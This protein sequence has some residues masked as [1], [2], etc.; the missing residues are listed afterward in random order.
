MEQTRTA[1]PPLR[2]RRTVTGEVRR[3]WLALGLLAVLLAG[4]VPSLLLSPGV[5]RLFRVGPARLSVSDAEVGAGGRYGPVSV[6]RG[7]FYQIDLQADGTPPFT[8][9]LDY[10]GGG[11][12]KRF[13]PPVTFDEA[14]REMRPIIR[15]ARD[16]PAAAV[17]VEITPGAESPPLRVRRLEVYEIRAA[18]YVLR[19]VARAGALFVLLAGLSVFGRRLYLRWSG[20]AGA[21]VPPRAAGW[22]AALLTLA[23]GFGAFV[24][25]DRHTRLFREPPSPSIYGWDGS[26]YY[27]WLRSAMV[28]GDVD[29]A[30]DLRACNSMPAALRETTL[31][32]SPRTPRGL[33][34]NKYPVGWALLEAPW[35]GAADVA[36]RAVNAAGGS[37][38]RDGWGPLYQAFLVLGQIAYALAGL[39]LAYRVLTE[40][41]PPPCAAGSVALGW[42]CSPLAYYQTLNV[43]MAHN[44]MFFA[45]MGAY[46]SALA[47]RRDPA[48]LRW[49]VLVGVCCAL[50]ILARYQGAVLLLF[51]GAVCL[52]EV[53]RAPRRWAHLAAGLAASA[54]PLAVQAF[55]WKALYGS[56]LLYTYEGEGFDWARPHLWESLFSSYHGLFN[57]HPAL[58]AGFAGFG[59][60][61]AANRRR[62]EAWCFAA[63]LALTI[64][65][66]AAW[67]CWW[68]GDSFGGRAFEG[69][70]LFAML[71]FGWTMRALAGRAAP[72]HTA[73]ALG[74]LAALW[75][76]NLL[77][78]SHDGPLPLTRPVSWH[79]RLE[80]T[81]RHWFPGS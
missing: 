11:G 52:Q 44:V 76:M 60:W 65:V 62:A 37:V 72:F 73:A 71:G 8:V 59:A 81:R 42:L 18:F 68:F 50:A 67:Q 55:A 48:R 78:L 56:W 20:G 79:E 36:A 3:R 26:F 13:R 6:A 32:D 35:Y 9:R 15:A 21:P 63:S 46:A 47:L 30:K 16:D 4:A 10:D 5:A 33:I 74:L 34:P 64:Y 31:R 1:R 77:W 28:E 41:L 14:A 54:V 70:T 49:W 25:Q 27:Y 17:A 43:A 75:S 51:P 38:P 22:A 2:E 57:W 7:H 39:W 61:A 69:C 53:W 24:L 58:L 40:W 80:M 45:V 23:V 29:F 66:N 12:T 19:A